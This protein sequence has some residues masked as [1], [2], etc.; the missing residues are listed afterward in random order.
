MVGKLNDCWDQVHMDKLTREKRIEHGFFYF[1][2]S[3][4]RSGSIAVYL[5]N[6]LVK[7]HLATKI[8]DHL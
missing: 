8:T 1:F 3:F 4:Q 5:T 7:N 6:Q 2:I